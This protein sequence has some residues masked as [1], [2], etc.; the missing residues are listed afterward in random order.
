MACGTLWCRVGGAGVRRLDGLADHYEILS[1]GRTR[2]MTTKARPIPLETVKRLA[3]FTC[4]GDGFLT[5]FG[6]LLL[7][8]IA[9][10]W[11]V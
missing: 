7:R 5:I 4:F 1:R 11:A 10:A 2:R 6:D 9:Y 8:V 3:V